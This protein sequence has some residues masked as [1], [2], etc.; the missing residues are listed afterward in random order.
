MS[1]IQ[2]DQL[3]KTFHR[4]IRG[5]GALGAIR[6]LINRRYEEK[7]AVDRI[8]FTIERGE[9]VGYLG[10]NGAGKS[11]SIKM[12]VGILVPT[13]GEVRVDGVIPYKNRK[14]N[15]SKIGV[16]FGQRSQLWWDIPVSE[17]FE[18]MKYMYNIPTADFKRNIELFTDV[19]GIQDFMHV[20]V[21][22]LSLGQR[23]RADLCA[24]LLHNP[25]IVYLDEPTIGLD[26]VV[27]KKI[28]EFLLEVNALRQTTILLTTHDMSDVEKL[29]SRVII[30]NNGRK[31][32]DGDLE[33]LKSDYS[34]D[35]TMILH[36]DHDEI[37]FDGNISH[38]GVT[39]FTYH[40]ESG[41]ILLRYDKRHAKPASILAWFMERT[42]V[43][44]FEI[45]PA[46]V[47]DVIR[48]IYQDSTSCELGEV[49]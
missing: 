12:L 19:L 39:D 42:V 49:Q 28:R 11:T 47:E 38:L 20:A 31:M 46:E 16:V 3:T 6:D 21:R 43:H 25:S 5:T 29:C 45:K 8:S 15:A 44:D 9:I 13:S 24:A 33:R 26:V 10:P 37:G 35:E 22:Q 32:F 34:A 4:P 18:L 40:P 36:V 30:I 48:D 17:T 41:S 27:K 2:V 7:T 1:I 23:M 14:E